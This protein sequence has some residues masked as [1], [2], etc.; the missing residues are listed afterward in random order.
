M[1]HK[2]ENVAYCLDLPLKAR[3]H[4]VFHVSC[5]KKKLGAHVIPLPTLPLV[6]VEGA[7]QPE[8]EAILDRGVRHK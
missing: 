6:D 1:L 2:I 8:H 5:L 3:I 4:L 7:L